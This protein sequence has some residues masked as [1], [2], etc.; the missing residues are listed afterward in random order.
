MCVVALGRV[1]GGACGKGDESKD[2]SELEHFEGGDELVGGVNGGVV[3]GV[4][5]GVFDCVFGDVVGECV[6]LRL[7]LGAGKEEDVKKESGRDPALYTLPFHLF[8]ALLQH[9]C[10]LISVMLSEKHERMMMGD[11]CHCGLQHALPF[12]STA[13]INGAHT[14]SGNGDN[15]IEVSADRS[16][17]FQ[18]LL[19]LGPFEGGRG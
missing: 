15:T 6:V 1:E 12:S 9:F 5:G 8:H 10:Y 19:H 14:L 7:M 13:K 2:E 11:C 4:F 17:L 3:G 16:L 18:I